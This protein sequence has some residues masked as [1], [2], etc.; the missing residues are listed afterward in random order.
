MK[1]TFFYNTERKTINHHL[2]LHWFSDEKRNCLSYKNT[3]TALSHAACTESSFIF[4]V[5]ASD[6]SALW[7]G[8]RSI[9]F[10]RHPAGNQYR[11]NVTS[12]TRCRLVVKHHALYF[13][14][15]SER[16]SF[17]LEW[18][19]GSFFVCCCHCASSP[20]NVFAFPP[21]KMHACGGW[22]GMW[23]RNIF[24]LQQ[25]APKNEPRR[26]RFAMGCDWR[27]RY[28][29][30][31][32][33]LRAKR[34]GNMCAAAGP[35]DEKLFFIVIAC[36]LQGRYWLQKWICLSLMVRAAFEWGFDSERWK[37]HDAVEI[38][39]CCFP[40]SAVI[41]SLNM[42]YCLIENLLQ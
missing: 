31:A 27:K 30:V 9:C 18:E 34:C 20:E 22:K 42:I 33:W 21:P 37:L 35:K 23:G 16:C 32:V 41:V 13:H 10:S 24:A 25:Q 8:R 5:A 15:R 39:G 17:S 28:L 12:L 6:R 4:I 14:L 1:H 38:V 11:K 36:A 2:Q 19:R 26:E 7:R 29:C 3:Y 40:H